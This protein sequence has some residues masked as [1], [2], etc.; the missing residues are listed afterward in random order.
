MKRAKEWNYECPNCESKL[1]CKRYPEPAKERE[2][3]FCPLCMHSLPARDG[4]YT[5]GYVLIEK[6]SRI[7]K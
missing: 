4:D 7:I 3:A 2:Q 1:L 6:P 5:L